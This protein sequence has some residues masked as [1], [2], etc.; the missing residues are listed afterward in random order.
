MNR[1]RTDI[2][3]LQRILHTFS[4]FAPLY[5]DRL[6]NHLPM[7]ATALWQLGGD[8][9]TIERFCRNYASRL[10]RRPESSAVGEGIEAPKFGA[11]QYFEHNAV[12]FKAQIETSSTDAVL[13]QWVPRLL[14]GLSASAFHGL[15]RTAYAVEAGS[16]LEIADALASWASDYVE[17][18]KPLLEQPRASHEIIQELVTHFGSPR[19]YPGIIIDKMIAVSKDAYFADGFPLPENLSINEI[20]ATVLGLYELCDDFTLLHAVTATHAMRVLLPF[21]D[22][23]AACGFLWQGL[24]L[25]IA[26][27]ADVIVRNAQ[28]TPAGPAS[29]GWDEIVQR[30]VLS[31]DD[32]V[33]KLVYTAVEESALA[34]E[35]GYRRIAAR[36]VKLT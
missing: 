23:K 19:N 28:N 24:L 16:P 31:M 35:E 4:T 13:R 6:A 7:A 5:G 33:I 10:L 3:D 36:K 9:A 32:H 12:F 15:I 26:T 2:R 11:P 27:V 29:A 1:S 20:R 17:F 21:V 22:S 14:P 25:A 8:A 18:G 30:S 34:D